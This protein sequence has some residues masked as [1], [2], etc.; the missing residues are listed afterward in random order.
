[1][2]LRKLTLQHTA[3]QARIQ[4][5]VAV[6]LHRLSQKLVFPRH[7]YLVDGGHLAA[8][9]LRTGAVAPYALVPVR[10]DS[11][12]LRSPHHLLHSPARGTWLLFCRVAASDGAHAIQQQ[13]TQ[14]NLKA[15]QGMVEEFA[16]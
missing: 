6:R 16:L 7:A 10:S 13:R 3:F 5:E 12:A 15:F 8:Y 4:Q 11:G 14:C 1:M 9:S 2:H